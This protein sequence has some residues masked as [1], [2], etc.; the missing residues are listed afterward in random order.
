VP[1]NVAQ[2][3]QVSQSTPR[4]LAIPY[5]LDTQYQIYT[6]GLSPLAPSL[7]DSSFLTLL[8]NCLDV[9]ASSSEVVRRG[10][11]N[12]F[13]YETDPGRVGVL[14]ALTLPTGA[15]VL[16]I[17]GTGGVL[18]RALGERGFNVTALY[19]T[20]AGAACIAE[21]CRGLS[22]VR[23]FVD[24]VEGFV[25]PH[26]F[27]VVI[28]VDPLMAEGAQLDPLGGVARK[29]RE[30]LSPTGTL[31]L[32]VGNIPLT[33]DDHILAHTRDHIRGLMIPPSAMSAA[34]SHVGFRHIETLAA[35]P[36]HAAPE[37]LVHNDISQEEKLEWDRV[38]LSTFNAQ[39]SVI[40]K[41]L[42]TL[43]RRTHT[44]N[45][46]FNPDE[47]AP[48][49]VFLAHMHRV[50]ALLWNGEGAMRFSLAGCEDKRG[51]ISSNN[52]SDIS[53]VILPFADP[54]IALWSYHE[55]RPRIV[56]T[57]S[58]DAEMQSVRRELGR[59]LAR[60]RD[61]YAGL[62]QEEVKLKGEFE[63]LQKVTSSLQHEVLASERQ[64][65]VLQEKVAMLTGML[66]EE[67]RR[68]DAF[69]HEL[70]GVRV[71]HRA[72]FREMNRF[73]EAA[74]SALLRV[75]ELQGELE[76]T[77][78]RLNVSEDAGKLA[79]MR[80]SKM[81]K[82]FEDLDSYVFA[83]EGVVE[84]LDLRSAALQAELRAWKG[85]YVWRFS[86]ALSRIFRWAKK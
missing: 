41:V 85:T 27:D 61:L 37:V 54:T 11:E 64:I 8:S 62:A 80:E 3:S 53:E 40:P 19:P 9:S 73:K 13:R 71:Q 45:G 44:Y 72:F 67:Q 39:V 42:A 15:K 65:E 21:R 83:L 4:T 25:S 12:G 46:K 68:A 1:M 38:A 55:N 7:G 86:Q 20:V 76:Y 22:N 29:A 48:G 63:D 52:H 6:R 24:S 30:I 36:H 5:T 49:C 59:A 74:E 66:Q 69:V 75:Q 50:H 51:M 34:L 31:I 58:P 10:I 23:V 47:V 82:R 70:Q 32:A 57:I 16:E 84:R 33:F 81:R 56:S 35:Y 78:E 2:F 26:P 60:E 14:A 17:G 43:K 79:S 77:R 28:C 18:S